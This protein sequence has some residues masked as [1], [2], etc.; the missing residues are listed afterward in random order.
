MPGERRLAALAVLAA[1]L[2]I[3]SCDG[4]RQRLVVATSLP[5]ALR[6]DVEEAF[7]TEHPDV[8]V[9][10]VE[11]EGDGLSTA[12]LGNG[13]VWWGGDAV[14]MRQ[15]ELSGAIAEWAL[16]ATT[17]LVIAFNRELVQLSRAPADW[18]D[19]FHHRW[20]DEVAVPDPTR[21]PEGR[22][23]AS[24]MIVEALRDDDDL[25]RGFDWLMRLD[26]QTAEYYGS[27]DDALRALRL[28]GSG[29]A[30]LPRSAAEAARARGASWMHYRIPQS[31]TPALAFG[32]AVVA[33]TDAS[34]PARR[35]YDFVRSTDVLTRTKLQTWWEPLDPVDESAVPEDFMLAQG[36]SAFPLAIDTL[37]AE[38][39]DWIE[40]WDRE[41]RGRG[42]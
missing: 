5:E 34:G 18:V 41:V 39:Q 16:V 17:P 2:G 38:S 20:T 40:R 26:V 14:S 19:V 37:A 4:A 25:A 28:G 21:T 1:T 10:F 27:V 7:E 30:V 32:V 8:D 23:F 31:G 15:H 3:V 33:G 29:L 9:S 36:L 42:G 6:D 12:D 24:A 13:D 35:F 11:V 22:T